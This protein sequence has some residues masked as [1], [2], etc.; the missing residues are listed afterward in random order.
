MDRCHC[1]ATRTRDESRG[2]FQKITLGNISGFSKAG[3]LFEESENTYY[4]SVLDPISSNIEDN[5]ILQ[6]ICSALIASVDGRPLDPTSSSD[7]TSN[8]E[9]HSTPYAPTI[10]NS[11]QVASQS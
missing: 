7:H 9:H 11:E 2:C 6:T 4:I 1:V 8:L 3:Y 5:A 10:Q